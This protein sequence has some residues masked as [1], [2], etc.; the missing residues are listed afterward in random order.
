MCESLVHSARKS[1][2]T[3]LMLWSPVRRI[4]R[5]LE[6]ILLMASM[7]L[8]GIGCI[9]QQFVPLLLVRAHAWPERRNGLAPGS[10]PRRHESCTCD[11]R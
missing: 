11:A 4:R 6:L 3:L 8:I 7:P 2:S 1:L 10:L 9:P 5:A